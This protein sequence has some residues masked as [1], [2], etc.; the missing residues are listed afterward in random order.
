MA[1][2]WV[3]IAASLSMGLGAVLLFIHGVKK[4]WFRNIEDAKYQGF[5]SD[6]EELVDRS[7]E[8]QEKENGT[9]S[10]KGEAR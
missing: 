9:A 5:W 8:K 6:L 7:H 4:D 10:A 3:A 2:T 1:V